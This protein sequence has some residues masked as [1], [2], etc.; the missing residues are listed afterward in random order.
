[1]TGLVRTGTAR[2]GAITLFLI[3][4]G[5]GAGGTQEPGRDTHTRPLTPFQRQRAERLLR[6][7]LPCLGCHRL[8]GEGGRIGPDLSRLKGR[9]PAYVYTM[10]RNPGATAPGTRM[11]RVPMPDETRDLIARYLLNHEPAAEAPVPEPPVVERAPPPTGPEDA[12]ALYGRFCAPC[13][14]ATGGGDGPN[15]PYLPVRPP[16]HSDAAYMSRRSDDALFDAIY[17]GGYIMDRSPRMPPFGGTLTADQIRSLVRHLR[18]LCGCQA[19][20]WAREGR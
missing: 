15:A 13:H 12:P 11:P 14:G 7:R 19:P 8:D 16:A 6:D 1:M 20:G 17:A 2:I 4:A 5:P 10:I 18:K 9:D 3:L